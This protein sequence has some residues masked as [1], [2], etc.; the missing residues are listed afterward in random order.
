MP[1][2]WTDASEPV[3]LRDLVAITGLTD[4]TIRADISVGALI[5]T[6]RS[7]HPSSP[8]LISR[9]NARMW[10]Q[11]M[12]Y[13]P[14]PAAQLARTHTNLLA[15]PYETRLAL[16]HLLLELMGLGALVRN[17]V[18]TANSLTG[19]TDGLQAEITHEPWTG[20]DG[21]GKPSYGSAVTRTAVVELVSQHARPAAVRLDSGEVLVVRATVTIL[22]PITANA[23]SGRKG[24]VD[25][26]DRITLPDGTT[27]PILTINAP[28]DPATAAPYFYEIGIG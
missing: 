22:S 13:Q 18:A 3:R 4:D 24:P 20:L 17:A 1:E 5:A 16:A 12:G 11:R 7:P 25:P 9:T 14:T 23:A 26:R 2:V 28:V 6:K 21:Y 27:G 19:G 10:L 15:T 8:W